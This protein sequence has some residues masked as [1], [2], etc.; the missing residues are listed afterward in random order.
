MYIVGLT[1]F[2][3]LQR[4][5]T[6]IWNVWHFEISENG[7][8]VKIRDLIHHIS[9]VKP[10]LSSKKIETVFVEGYLDKTIIEHSIKHFYPQCS[11]LI[12]IQTINHGGGASWVERQLFIWAKY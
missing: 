5:F 1:Q 7:W 12:N 8:A 6:N 2:Q 10:Q 11:H 4:S 9:L 3:D